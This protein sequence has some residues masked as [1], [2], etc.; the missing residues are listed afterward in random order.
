MKHRRLSL[1]LIAALIL[2]ISACGRSQPPESPS[3]S[4]VVT[5]S[6]TPPVDASTEALYAEAERVYLKFRELQASYELTGDYSEFPPEMAD[7]LGPEYLERVRT[8]FNM[9]KEG[10]WNYVGEPGEVA[11]APA[12][13]VHKGDSELTLQTCADS[14]GMVVLDPT[15]AVVRE[16]S[17]VVGFF[18]FRHFDGDLK[19]VDSDIAQESECPIA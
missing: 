6:T 17:M 1:V 2:T 15:G 4:P 16:G 14:R 5:S 10:N 3:P 18:Y 19:I 8:T 12:P 7:Y 11:T 9:A 13:S